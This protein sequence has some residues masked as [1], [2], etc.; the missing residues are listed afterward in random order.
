MW[1]YW[2]HLKYT[3]RHKYHVMVACTKEGMIL[4]GILHDL[5]KFTP[6]E[7]TG[8][9]NFFFNPDGSR[10]EDLDANSE[11]IKRAFGDA[12]LHHQT[13]NA[14]HWQY[15]IKRTNGHTVVNPMPADIAAEMICDWIGAARANY[16]NEP[17]IPLPWYKQNRSRILL[18]TDTRN[19]I[20]M[21]IGF[22]ESDVIV[23][24]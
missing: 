5:S 20:E 23:T 7:F 24:K 17:G 2:S 4:R 11:E 19:Y 3:I 9:A 22:R 1:Q 12:F 10:K 18:H 21:K 16:Q 8:Y 6:S 14:H 15:W 13:S